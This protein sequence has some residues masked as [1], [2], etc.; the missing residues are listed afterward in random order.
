MAG[1]LL[2]ID[3]KLSFPLIVRPQL[4][5]ATATVHL[6]DGQSFAVSGRPSNRRPPDCGAIT[7]ARVMI[8]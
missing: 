4:D 2:P 7:A 6:D 8:P 3:R 5:I 1:V